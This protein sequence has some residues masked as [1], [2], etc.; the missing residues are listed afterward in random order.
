MKKQKTLA[1][2]ELPIERIPKDIRNQLRA[3]ASLRPGP[4]MMLGCILGDPDAIAIR[5][6]WKFQE[7]VLIVSPSE[8]EDLCQRGYTVFHG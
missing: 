3:A 8:Y 5:D 1:D 6:A 2:G 4:A 7:K